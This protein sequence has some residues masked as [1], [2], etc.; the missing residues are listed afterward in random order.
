M[1]I[2]LILFILIPIAEIAAFIKVG[3]IIGLWSTIAVIILTA[4]VGSTLVR[5]QGLEVLSKF[6]TNVKSGDIPLEPAV[7]GM[8]LL[9]SGLLL[10][11]PGFL[12]DIIGFC[13]LIPPLRSKLGHMVWERIKTSSNI[14]VSPGN[15]HNPHHTDKSEDRAG[16]IIEGEIILEHED[17]KPNPESKWA[18]KDDRLE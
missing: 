7:H 13:L 18:K 4:I 6:K 1:P 15:M 17:I 3:D 12:T 2:L 11:T 10:I 16:A 14:H 5:Q 8:F 9:V